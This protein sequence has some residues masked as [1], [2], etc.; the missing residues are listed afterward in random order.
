M[1]ALLLVVLAAPPSSV[2]TG[3]TPSTQPAENARSAV[4]PAYLQFVAELERGINAREASA[5]DAHLDLEKLLERTTR[6]ISAPAGFAEGF[7]NGVRSAKNG[8][9]GQRVVAGLGE[10]GSF[11]LL[12][13]RMEEGAPRALF[14]LLPPGGGVN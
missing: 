12:R 8:S 5:L 14:R 6:G 13:L 11:Q 4:A 3:S 1:I 2:P 10:D 7:K 9:L